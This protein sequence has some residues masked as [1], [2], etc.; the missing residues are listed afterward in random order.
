MRTSW[1]SNGLSFSADLS[2]ISN[3]ATAGGIKDV[4][5]RNADD[6]AVMTDTVAGLNVHGS[7]GYAGFSALAEYTTALDNFEAAD[8][9]YR[10]DGAQPAALNTELAYGTEIAGLDT[11][12]ALGFQ[13]TWE[14]LALEVP[15]FRY[16]VA[17]AL[18][19]FEGTTLTLEYL[20]A[21]SG[22]AHGRRVDASGDHAGGP[23]VAGGGRVPRRC[24]A[25]RP[26][27][28]GRPD[29]GGRGGPPDCRVVGGGAAGSGRRRRGGEGGGPRSRSEE[30]RVGK[31][32]RSRWSP[33]H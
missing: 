14:A 22:G 31:E 10:G 8:L 3:L 11:E 24:A 15:E 27:D 1:N 7:I 20:V 12:F 25:A 21:G 4:L 28:S 29:P 26:A 19:I 6:K 9:E 2:M 16:S 30:R 23:G 17:V 5:P 18:G 33:Y 13:K 32:C